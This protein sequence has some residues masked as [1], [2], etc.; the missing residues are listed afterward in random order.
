MIAA[1]ESETVTHGKMPRLDKEKVREAARGQGP[2]IL[3][4]L[5]M[6]LEILSETLKYHICPEC[7]KNTFCFRDP[8]E[9]GA[10]CQN[11]DCK[12]TGLGD[13]FAFVMWIRGCTFDDAIQF[14]ADAIGFTSSRPGKGSSARP[15]EPDVASE[16]F[17]KSF[18][19]QPNG[20]NLLPFF[21]KPPITPDGLL[22]VGAQIGFAHLHPKTSPLHVLA[23]P[24]Y[25]PTTLDLV[26]RELYHPSGAL[27]LPVGKG[28][29]AKTR[30]LS[31][32]SAIVVSLYGLSL[33]RAGAQVPGLR[34][35]K[36]EG[37]SDLLAV[38]SAIDEKAANLLVFSNTD[39][40][41]GQ[42]TAVPF[43]K[44]LAATVKPV[45]IHCVG[46]CDKAG[47]E[48]LIGKDTENGHRKAGWAQI[49]AGATQGDC[50]VHTL[51]YPIEPKK[52]KDLRDW[53]N[54]GNGVTGIFDLP[55][56]R[57]SPVDW[58]SLESEQSEAEQTTEERVAE[59]MA[60][61]HVPKTLTTREL[62]DH[63]DEDSFLIDQTLVEKQ[64]AIVAGPSKSMKTTLSIDAAISLATGSSFLGR[65]I[66]K[67][68]PVLFLTSEI[69][70]TQVKK[71]AYRIAKFKGVHFQLCGMSDDGMSESDTNILH[72]NTW[73]PYIPDPEQLEILDF[74]IRR[75][76]AK[77]VFLDPLY[78]MLDGD[79]AA[80]YSLN[81]QQL[82]ALCS[83]VL[84]A[85]ATPICNDHAKR[86]S[87]NAKEHEPLE[88]D[89]ISGAGKA[90]Y[91][92]QWMLVSRR[93]RFDETEPHKLWLSIGGSAFAGSTVAIDIDER[94]DDAGKRVYSIS[95]Q[96]AGELRK[97]KVKQR[98]EQ[99]AKVTEDRLDRK[100]IELID[101]I[102]K[103][104]LS[105]SLSKNDFQ[106]RIGVPNGEAGKVIGK[107]INENRL[108]LV[109][110]S[111]VK[112]GRRYDG[113][114]LPES[115][116]LSDSDE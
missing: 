82:R 85:G 97:A 46:D 32:E 45:S 100:A 90:E 33:L 116:P 28:E 31:G 63:T 14:V 80:S 79:T 38:L 56:G 44:K 112:N 6:G 10:L 69:G 21:R 58:D 89:D 55:A 87:T 54:E 49:L 102:Y 95:S 109:P 19:R 99:R 36:V 94:T 42:K 12:P 71:L 18:S 110:L 77:A 107:L 70:L 20:E 15:R 108:R 1:K 65:T 84:N 74:E 34:G 51:P 52:G 62:F 35:L 64:P 72:W 88:L 9:G 24:A 30:M 76:G 59:L 27:E 115:L 78:L 66:P 75:V 47:Q 23:I 22:L 57:V 7:G 11:N 41:I 104:D 83:V 103:S 48:G 106:D 101:K 93:E 92:R 67:P 43:A 111:L 17:A 105:L 37:V 68:V 4:A 16:P 60:K 96:P 91:F 5:G 73:V 61:H 13:W 25:D 113:Y 98:G 114:M 8:E 26:D 53:L 3:H 40:A 29:T 50:L 81:A 2:A 86:S 39:G